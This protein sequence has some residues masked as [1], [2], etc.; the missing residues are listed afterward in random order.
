MMTPLCSLSVFKLMCPCTF[1]NTVT[2]C[3]LYFRC[4]AVVLFVAKLTPQDVNWH[5][6]KCWSTHLETK[7]IYISKTYMFCI[8][9]PPYYSLLFLNYSSIAPNRLQEPVNDE[10]YRDLLLTSLQQW[11]TSN[12]QYNACMITFQTTVVTTYTTCSNAKS[13]LNSLPQSLVASFLW[14]SRETGIISI[15]PY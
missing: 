2:K 4:R 8:K 13:V 5:G 7:E 6:F 9:A 11:I 14:I 1:K 12:E 3:V 15:K 10:V